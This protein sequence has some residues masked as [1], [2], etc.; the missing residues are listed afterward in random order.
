[1]LED[2]IYYKDEDIIITEVYTIVFDSS[3]TSTIRVS[4]KSGMR[5]LGPC[6]GGAVPST[7]TIDFLGFSHKIS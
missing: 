3:N 6:G 1:M 7:L 5:G 4:Y 2:I